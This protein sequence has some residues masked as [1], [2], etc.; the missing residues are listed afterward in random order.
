MKEKVEKILSH[1][2]TCFINRQL[3]YNYPEQLFADAGVMAIGARA[4]ALLTLPVCGALCPVH[5][6]RQVALCRW[7]RTARAAR[8]GW[9]ALT[10]S[11]FLSLARA[12]AHTRS[13]APTVA[14]RTGFVPLSLLSSPALMA[15]SCVPSLALCPR[16][17]STP[18]LPALSCAHRAHACRARRL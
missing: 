14:E 15:S 12:H 4:L 11:L 2:I 6:Q 18:T 17:D 7:P 1:N 10:R 16:V 5:P 13:P 3:I 9:R 8:S